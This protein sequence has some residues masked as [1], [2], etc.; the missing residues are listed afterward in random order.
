MLP[1]ACTPTSTAPKFDNP[2]PWHDVAASY[3]R[4]EYESAIYDTSNGDRVKIA[5]GTLVFTLTEQF[6]TEGTVGYSKLE[7]AFSI[8]YNESAP[9]L[10]CGKT[11]TIESAVEFQT[12]SLITR[13]ST[14]TVTLAERTGRTDLSYAVSAD[15]FAGTAERTMYGEKSE[16]D[17]EQGM[18]YD[19][20]M[21]YFL[22]R[23]TPIAAGGQTAF[24]S[25]NLFDSFLNGKIT[26]YNTATRTASEISTLY[27]DAW[28]ADFGVQSEQSDTDE[29]VYPVK[30]FSTDIGIN[31]SKSGPTYKVHYSQEPFV[32]N[33]KSHA[34][35]PLMIAYPQYSGA[36]QVRMNEYRLV[37]CSFEKSE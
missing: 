33:G 5:D 17:V 32:K 28:V 36:A 1:V 24:Y 31:A 21:L 3:E 4:L 6:E 16:L 10:D 2:R 23:A 26:T 19:N 13:R 35:I 25:T 12:D 7:T 27:F 18:Y 22:A 20:E 9:E 37:S 34:K 15:Y 30:C 11:D 14:K 29:T 8:T